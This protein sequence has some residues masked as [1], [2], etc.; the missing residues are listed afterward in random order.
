MNRLLIFFALLGL[1]AGCG[2]GSP[3]SP[4][5]G[6]ESPVVLSNGFMNARL[7]GVRWDAARIA[8][9]IVSA[10][11]SP[12]FLGLVGESDPRATGVAIQVQVSHS[13]GTHTVAIG[14]VP[15]FVTLLLGQQGSEAVWLANLGLAGSSGTVT[16]DD[17]VTRG[18]A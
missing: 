7:D 4:S 14:S 3:T 17:G 16:P 15:T 18:V 1:V 5:G 2:G 6:S 11:P 12:G 8:A 9:G 10:G 13:V